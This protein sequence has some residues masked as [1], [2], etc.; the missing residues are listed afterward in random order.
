MQLD[1]T[2]VLYVESFREERERLLLQIDRFEPKTQLDQVLLL[3]GF[4][5][6]Q[7][8]GEE[9]KLLNQVLR[10]QPVIAYITLREPIELRRK[11]RLPAFFPLYRVQDTHEQ[12][13]TLAFGQAALLLEA[14]SLGRFKKQDEENAPIFC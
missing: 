5:I 10:R 2:L 8:R 14:E 11:L 3:K 7:P 1:H 6:T 4:A 12:P 9:I 13:Y